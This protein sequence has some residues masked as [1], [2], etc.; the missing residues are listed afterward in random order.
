MYAI[1]SY[2]AISPAVMSSDLP[3]N[4]SGPAAGALKESIQQFDDK[5]TGPENAGKMIRLPLG[6]KIQSMAMQFA[7]AQLIETLRFTREDISAAYGVLL[8]MVDGSFVV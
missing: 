1:R 4:L 7:D 8:G 2:Y 3:D 6:H 5:Y